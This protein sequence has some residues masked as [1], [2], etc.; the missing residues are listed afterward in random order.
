MDSFYS[1]NLI[2]IQRGKT[3]VSTKIT[4][5]R[6]DKSDHEVSF[7]VSKILQMYFEE[8]VVYLLPMD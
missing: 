7:S 8:N 4:V 2:L 5:S 1:R 6:K 3:Q